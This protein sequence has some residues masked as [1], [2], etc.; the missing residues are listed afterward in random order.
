LNEGPTQRIEELERR[1][2]ALIS[3]LTSS[4]VIKPEELDATEKAL[5]DAALLL[6]E[7]ET[8]EPAEKKAAPAEEDRQCIVC[9]EEA[10][11]IIFTGQGHWKVCDETSCLDE[12]TQRYMDPTSMT[13]MMTR[14]LPRK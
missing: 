14:P 13:T 9:G 12:L 3:L 11:K 6:D 7:L 2:A 4:G 10:T 5:S 8:P 1:L